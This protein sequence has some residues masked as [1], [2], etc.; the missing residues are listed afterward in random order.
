MN[1]VLRIPKDRIPKR[2]K[3][4]HSGA[5]N[6]IATVTRFPMQIVDYEDAEVF[7]DELEVCRAVGLDIRVYKD[8]D[9]YNIYDAKKLGVK[10]YYEIND[11]HRD[12]WEAQVN[13]PDEVRKYLEKL[14]E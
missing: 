8:G 14:V 1:S 2:T 3:K 10:T 13:S 7:M 12:E 11:H 9:V 6:L 5:E 4:E